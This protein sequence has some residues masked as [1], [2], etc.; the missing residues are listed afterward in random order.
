MAIDLI[1]RGIGMRN[2]KDIAQGGSGIDSMRVK[3]SEEDD[4]PDFLQ[5][6]INGTDT[7]LKVNVVDNTLILSL[8]ESVINKIDS[9]NSNKICIDIDDTPD[10]LENK[11]LG[12]TNKIDVIKDE[13]DTSNKL[14]LSVGKDIFDKT[15][16]SANSIIYNKTGSTL[17][18]S[19]VGDALNELDTKVETNTINT[20]SNT[21]DVTDL[22]NSQGKIKLNVEDT[23]DYLGNKVDNF[24]IQIEN[25]KL[26]VKTLNGLTVPVETINLLQGVTT[27]IQEQ[28][29]S[30][31][32]AFHLL[33]AKDTYTQLNAIESPSIGD[34]WIINNDENQG[35]VRDWYTYTSA[36]WILMGVVEV[37]VRNFTTNPINLNTEVTGN[38]SQN[39]IDLTGLVKQSDLGNYLDKS[40]YDKDNNHQ[41]D[42]SDDSDKLGSQ[43]PTYYTDAN[44]INVDSSAFNKNLTVNDNTVQKILNKVDQLTIGSSGGDG[45]SVDLSD[46]YNKE[47]V[48]NMLFTTS[49][50]AKEIILNSINDNNVTVDN[51]FAEVSNRI[52]DIKQSIVDALNN[53]GIGSATKS[54]KLVS[55]ADKISAIIQNSQIKNTKLNKN[56]G[57]TYQA[58]LTNPADITDVATSVLEYIAGDSGIVQ[59]DCGF[60]NADSSQFEDNDT[61]IYDGTM[62]QK[63]NTIDENMIQGEQLVEG[64]TYTCD[65]DKTQFRKI[66]KIEDVSTDTARILEITS[67][68]TSTL[69]LANGDIDLNGVD[70]IDSITLTAICENKSKLLLIFSIDSGITW[71]GYDKSTETVT[72]IDI[73]NNS[74]IE[75]K[76]ISIDNINN[77]SADDLKA[78]RQDSSKIR[79]GYYFNMEDAND[80]VNNN[81]IKI[82]VDMQGTNVFSKNVDISLGND[83]KTITYTFNKAGTFTVVYCDNGN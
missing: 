47:Q 41:V 4:A 24:T 9:A 82:T 25:G 55:Y 78:I 8:D 79:F 65:I 66:D 61:M 33:G 39:H 46:Y 42:K 44:N 31:T 26:A 32:Q 35:N 12:I 81:E 63:L 11:I 19:K 5:A 83:S 75:V 29:N 57:D 48:Q 20:N 76:G 77:A 68:Y 71:H 60:N 54:D 23:I 59:Y 18:S 17:K 51:T 36:G 50:E 72:D 73:S 3:V 40:T 53:K 80:T 1:A 64:V 13:V 58:I 74:D 69:V 43:L 2:T 67:T 52:L 7:Q 56:A 30:F 37:T 16:D 21:S 34:S 28:I 49:N 6:K 70:K 38:L 45:G 62:H 10:Y 27:N 14:I 22:K 15:I